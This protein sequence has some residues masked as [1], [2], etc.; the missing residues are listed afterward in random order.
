M[1][2]ILDSNYFNFNSVRIINKKK[3]KKNTKLKL[4]FKKQ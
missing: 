4:D 3:K 1:I 2:R